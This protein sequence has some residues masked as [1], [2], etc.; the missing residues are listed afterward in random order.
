MR[1]TLAREGY[2]LVVPGGTKGH[3]LSVAPLRLRIVPALAVR[4]LWRRSVCWSNFRIAR[5]PSRIGAKRRDHCLQADF[6]VAIRPASQ[7]P[8]SGPA[9]P[10]PAV[11]RLK[12]PMRSVFLIA[13]ADSTAVETVL[14]CVENAEISDDARRDSL[15]VGRKT[16]GNGHPESPLKRQGEQDNPVK[17]PLRQWNVCACARQQIFSFLDIIEDLTI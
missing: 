6:S 12:L 13:R 8:V 2:R 17:M 1:S 4:K 7:N 5:N 10:L 9:R 14:R 15:N 11:P 16:I 3:R